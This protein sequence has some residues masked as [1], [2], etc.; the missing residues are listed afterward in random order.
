[1]NGDFSVYI[2]E[3]HYPRKLSD[4]WKEFLKTRK[5]SSLEKGLKGSEPIKK[6]LIEI[7]RTGGKASQDDMK[8]FQTGEGVE[9]YTNA[10]SSLDISGFKIERLEYLTDDKD[11]KGKRFYEFSDVHE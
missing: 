10:A 4:S 8:Y 9:I 7:V 3:T 11:I 1:M 6:T 5:I 2:E